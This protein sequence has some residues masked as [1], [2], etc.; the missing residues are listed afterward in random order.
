M[1]NGYQIL[2]NK[3]NG[4]IRKYYR[5]Q[6]LKGLIFSMAILL[7]LFL[8]ADTLEF[9]G[10]FGTLTRTIIFYSFI[11]LAFVVLIY[12]I[13]IPLFGLARIGKVLSYEDAAR[14]IGTH[15]PEVSDKLLNTIQL[16]HQH[17]D[18]IENGEMD[19]ILAGI[20]QKSSE[21]RSNAAR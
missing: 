19:L 7:V 9:I 14:I 21:L 8:L 11:G 16:H 17:K 6:M 1:Q 15:F 2:V 20:D 10:W 3:I 12:Y 18:K 13:I 4:F 5:N